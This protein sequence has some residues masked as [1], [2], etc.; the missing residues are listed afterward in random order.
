MDSV[1]STRGA[2]QSF[3]TKKDDASHQ[4]SSSHHHGRRKKKSPKKSPPKS[5]LSSNAEAMGNMAS[6]ALAGLGEDD[7][8]GFLD[9]SRP[10]KEKRPKRTS[11]EQLQ[12][13][14]F[15]KRVDSPLSD[16]VEAPKTLET[17]VDD[18]EGSGDIMDYSAATPKLAKNKPPTS[19]SAYAGTRS[20]Q[21][22][23]SMDLSTMA[24]RTPQMRNAHRKESLQMQYSGNS[25]A[26]NH[27]SNFLANLRGGD[28]PLSMRTSDS[29]LHGMNIA[30]LSNSNI[31]MQDNT[32]EVMLPNNARPPY[33]GGGGGWYQQHP[34]PPPPPA[35]SG[36]P[37]SSQQRDIS[38]FAAMAQQQ[39][40]DISNFAAMAQQ[41]QQE[42]SNFSSM[43]TQHQEISNFSSMIQADYGSNHAPPPPVPTYQQRPVPPEKQPSQL[44]QLSRTIGSELLEDED[45]DDEEE[46]E[47]DGSY[48]FQEDDTLNWT[49]SDRVKNAMDPTDF[50]ISDAIAE[51]EDGHPIFDPHARWT[52]PSLLRHFLY[53]PEY[54]E[55]TS[56]QQFSWAVI[57]GV[58]MGIYTAIWKDIIEK[59]VDF[60]WETV[61]GKLHHWGVF[62]DLDGRFPLPNYVWMCPAFFGGVS[63]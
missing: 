8:G 7:I 5:E 33:Q 42:V 56:L 21:A 18:Y 48:S 57:L 20:Q 19:R 44:S 35:Y 10:L 51:D 32:V 60:V 31:M 27:D 9:G 34:P 59:C 12:P 29:G 24:D 61:P 23:Q 50:L 25:F 4:H 49:I 17:I 47:E 63:E 43:A 22:E 38:N 14:P 26:D 58:V 53:N 1:G 52:I 46:E 11:H 28:V 36:V 62:T 2:F 41:Q 3:V 55:F 15:A 13:H 16:D 37:M 30:G 39:Q 54:P 45:D 6:L 40:Q